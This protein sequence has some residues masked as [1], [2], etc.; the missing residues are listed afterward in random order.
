MFGLLKRH[1]ARAVRV[2]VH[3]YESVRNPIAP[4]L[5]MGEDSLV[6]NDPRDRLERMTVLVRDDG[7][8]V[9]DVE[10]I[11]H[12]LM[13]RPSPN[14]VEMITKQDALIADRTLPQ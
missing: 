10:I 6:V 1:R 12:A 3:A 2:Q 8:G 5:L 4:K 11:M 14:M 7:T 9:L 13:I